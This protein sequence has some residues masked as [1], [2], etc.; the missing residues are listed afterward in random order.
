MLIVFK[1]ETEFFW[2]VETP[3]GPRKFKTGCI[4]HSSYSDD[5]APLV[6]LDKSPRSNEAYAY[7]S[8]IQGGRVE[9]TAAKF[10]QAVG[11]DSYAII[12]NY[13]AKSV[14]GMALHKRTRQL[15]C[16]KSNDDTSSVIELRFALAISRPKGLE[17][18]CWNH[19][20]IYN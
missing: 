1:V 10:R 14:L 3:S 17:P 2:R 7:L 9:L 6:N 20:W 19:R 16:D 12:L 18:W 13:C 11:G 4:T 15:L 5:S 8:F